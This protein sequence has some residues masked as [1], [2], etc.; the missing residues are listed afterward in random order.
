MKPYCPL[1]VVLTAF[2]IHAFAGEFTVEKKPFTA[3][4]SLDGTFLPD[5]VHHL[6]IDPKVWADFTIVDLKTQGAPVKKGQPVVTLDTKEADRKLADDVDATQ[7]RKMALATAERE[8][9]NLEKSTPWRLD[10][11]ERAYKR[12]KDD[13]DYFNEVSRPLQEETAQRSLESAERYLEYATEELNQLLKM[14]KE[15]DLTEETEEII[16]KRQ[17][18]QVDSAEFRLKSSKI[19][20]KRTLETTIPRSAIDQ[21]QAFKDAELTWV[22][23]R[24]ALPR[25]LEQ[26][27]LEVKKARIDDQRA[28]E[29][30]AE[31]KADRAQMNVTSP[32]DGR[33]Y[34]GEIRDG[35][36]NPAGAAKFMKPGGKIAPRVIFASVIPDNAKLQVDAFADETVV[37]RLK[38]GQGGYAAPASAPRSR[39]PVK[40]R[41]VDTHPGVD[42][43]YHVVLSLTNLPEGLLVVPGMKG[44]IKVTT[45]SQE[46]DILSIPTNALH[47]EADGSYTVKVKGED[48]QAT[49]VPVEVGAESNGKIA[50]L[51]GL[52]E[53]Q[54]IIT[55]D[56]KPAPEKK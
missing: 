20:T 40:V 38:S 41:R 49:K 36:W 21:N 37:T 15:D 13:H 30:S 3:T 28:D 39:L 45:G 27:R 31:L 16:L 34:H 8:L 23:Q 17:R 25:A 50:V 48:G 53:G 19:S 9:E 18:N 43:K 52:Q 6:Q 55:P 44:K 10:A 47:E 32:T 51:S 1:L 56:P 29:K 54:V 26:K 7:L 33:V 2:P 22:T 35:R 5:T 12:A 42:G 4:V 46:G 11:A 14:Y 24:E